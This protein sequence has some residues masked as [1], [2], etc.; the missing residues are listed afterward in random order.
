MSEPVLVGE[1]VA[2]VAK[3]MRDATPSVGQRVEVRIRGAEDL[4]V[5]VGNV[6]EV[7]DGW[8]QQAYVTNLDDFV[9]V[10][11]G[12]LWGHWVSGRAWDPAAEDEVYVVRVVAPVD[13]S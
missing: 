5:R 11:P 8:P 2:Q 4:P 6:T 1:V 9:G 12:V 7:D 13:E 3:M 10:R